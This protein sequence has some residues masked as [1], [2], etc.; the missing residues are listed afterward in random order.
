MGSPADLEAFIQRC[1]VQAEIVYLDSPTPTVETAAAAVAAPVE[2]IVKSIL[3][4][5]EAGG[6]QPAPLLAVTSGLARVDRRQLALE[7]GVSRKRIHLANAGEV[8]AASGYEV[9]AM[10][11]FGHLQPLP[12]LIDSAIFDQPVVYAGGGSEHALMRLSPAEILR[13]TGGKVLRLR[14]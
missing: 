4:L 1:G 7:V 5:V 12:T 8:S 11:P 10:P 14:E 2:A 6:E 9:G 13:V 3:F